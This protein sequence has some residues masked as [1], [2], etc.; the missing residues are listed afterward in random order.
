MD[1][2][3]LVRRAGD[4]AS[5]V[6]LGCKKVWQDRDSGIVWMNE[7]GLWKRTVETTLKYSKHLI[8]N[9]L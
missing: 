2:Q 1:G 3:D 7:A 4:L 9:H 8:C 6:E 5:G